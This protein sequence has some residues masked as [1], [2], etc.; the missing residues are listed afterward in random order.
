MVKDSFFLIS[1]GCMKEFPDNSRSKF[2][3]VFQKTASVQEIKNELYIS[4]D[5]I[6]FEQTFSSYDN[7]STLAANIRDVSFYNEVTGVTSNYDLSGKFYTLDNLITALNNFV[8]K[9]SVNFMEVS[10]LEYAPNFMKL[11]IYE[12]NVLFS[13][14]LWEFL[15]LPIPPGYKNKNVMTTEKLTYTSLKCVKLI[16]YF[17]PYI[18]VKC[19]DVDPYSK[20]GSYSKIIAKVPLYHKQIGGICHYDSQLYQYFRLA[21][22][23]INTISIELL[24]PNGER[25]FLAAGSPTIIK[26][27]IKEMN[28]VNDFF[29]VQLSSEPTESE[30]LNN[31]NKFKVSLPHEFNLNG[32]WQVALTNLY[33]PSNKMNIFSHDRTMYHHAS[34][35]ERTIMFIK[36]KKDVKEF[37]PAP[38]KPGETT[39]VANKGYYK[40]NEI[41]FVYTYP[42]ETF[43]REEFIKGFHRFT[44]LKHIDI[45]V[46]ADENFLFLAKRET[47]RAYV[48]KVNFFMSKRL[49]NVLVKDKE[50]SNIS[51]SDL[52][53]F[54]Y[55]PEVTKNAINKFKNSNNGENLA[56]GCF[57]P[58]PLISEEQRKKWLT[59]FELEEYYEE[60]YYYTSEEKEDNEESKKK[61]QL[62]RKKVSALFEKIIQKDKSVESI[63]E[64]RES[65]PS[66]MFVYTDIVKPTIMAG[67]FNNLLKLVP[68]KNNAGSESGGFYN[69]PSVDFF[70]G[71]RSHL[72]T[73]EVNIKTHSGKEY[74]Y[75]NKGNVSMTLLFK[76]IKEKLA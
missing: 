54:D 14:K 36:H 52:L 23:I 34:V 1:T 67:N 5:Q 10:K 72:C 76:K 32:E 63:S 43:T 61:N 28:P 35:D 40:G 24:Q 48:M 7:S 19:D 74:K 26:A 66:W 27:N 39:P 16:E 57:D 56:R 37:I 22:N 4:L 69:F 9:S 49:Y 42:Y 25:L 68:Y 8:K 12:K 65:N 11:K 38:L 15:Q 46:D 44:E 53:D 17:P 64:L 21:S 31:C 29:Y 45:K 73:I 13:R 58:Y 6:N 2:K 3:N 75:Y 20:N 47:E 71:N 55:L 62:S 60:E 70:P 59:V 51:N 41:P 30:P 18:S 33:L 50:A